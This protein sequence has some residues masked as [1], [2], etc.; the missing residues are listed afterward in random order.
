M[1][2]IERAA[3]EQEF[4][5][6]ANIWDIDS[7]MGHMDGEDKESFNQQKSRIVRAIRGG[8]VAIDE[9]GS[10]CYTLKHPKGD[11]PEI[12]FN[13]PTGDAYVSM[14]GYKDR[15]G[16]HKLNAFLGSMTG[17]P[18]KFFARMDARDIK[19]CQA[20]VILFLAS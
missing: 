5:R 2:K 6:F 1:E 8:H 11:T 4:E 12:T 7:D 13:V 18:P 3:A 19:F 20:V 16:I 9:S 17:Q 14:D 10:L 15:Q